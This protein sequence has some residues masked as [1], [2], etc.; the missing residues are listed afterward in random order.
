MVIVGDEPEAQLIA[1]VRTWFKVLARSEWDS[2]LAM[3]DE[4]NIYGVR[5]TR[6]D[7]TRA[8]EETFGPGTL[9][10][11]ESGNPTFSDPELASGTAHH[12]FGEFDGGGFWLDYAVPLNGTFSDLSAQF[13]FH[14]RR[15]GYTVILHDLHVL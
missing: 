5:W 4:P 6:E 7:L 13:E 10:A 15:A 3:L 9:F 2:A 12:S 14:P 8:L 11:A 1:F